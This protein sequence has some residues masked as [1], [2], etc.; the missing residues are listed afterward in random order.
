MSDDI[1]LVRNFVME[2]E[3]SDEIKDALLKALILE[4]L[5]KPETEFDRLVKEISDKRVNEN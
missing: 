2:S 1:E 3:F 5:N 4:K